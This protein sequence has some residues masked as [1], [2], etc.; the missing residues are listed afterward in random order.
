MSQISQAIHPTIYVIFGVT[1]DL[2]RR[3][4]LPAMLHLYKEQ[5]LPE[6]FVVIGF[7]RR[8]WSDEEFRRQVHAVLYQSQKDIPPGFL[9][10]F[11]F[12]SG[13]FHEGGSYKQLALHIQKI[14]DTWKVCTNTLFHLAVSPEHYK[15]ILENLDHY[16]LDSKC[17]PK[18]GWTRVLV[19]KP[20]G[21][22][23][24]TA[25]KLDKLLGSLFEEKQIFRVDH[26]LGKETIQNILTFRF[27]NAIFEPIW[28]NTYIE[29]IEIKLLEDIDIGTRGSYYDP[30]GALRDVGQ[31]HMLQMLAL[32]AMDNPLEMNAKTISEKRTKVL[33]SIVSFT[34]KTLKTS[35]ARGQYKGYTREKN[36]SPQSKTETYFAIK[37]FIRNK[38]WRGVPFYLESGKALQKKDTRITVYFKEVMPCFCPPG[39]HSHHH[40]NTLQFN[41]QPNE[42]I[43]VKFLVKKP[44]LSTDIEPRELSFYYHRDSQV[45]ALGSYDK[46]IY[47]AIVGDQTLFSSTKEVLA[48]WKF[49]TPIVRMWN[50]LPLHIYGKG[51]MGPGNQ[52]LFIKMKGP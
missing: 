50:I 48:A 19:E 26:Y 30:I 34:K 16:G 39:H 37:A 41:I 38:R 32:I 18:E 15:I 44:G 21:N 33:K 20:F 28:N 11:H 4:L 46:L 42:G 36:V 27:S 51:S 29:K 40:N 22:D 25:Q 12:Q 24:A 13:D 45:L 23:L 10:M 7:S 3:M 49:I 52:F 35:V 47:D 1:G 2:A 31:N 8:D 43:S 9:E 17:G 14:D 6:K 5:A